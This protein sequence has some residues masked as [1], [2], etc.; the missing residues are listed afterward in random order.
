MC[1][2]A[3][4]GQVREAKRN[5]NSKAHRT[6]ENIMSEGSSGGPESCPQP[7]AKFTYSDC[8]AEFKRLT[9]MEIP[10]ASLGNVAI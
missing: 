4:L 1:T 3:S 10:L 6:H 2:W 8:P 9:R 5:Y 7:T